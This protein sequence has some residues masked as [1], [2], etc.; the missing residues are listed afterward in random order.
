MPDVIK[1]GAKPMPA[2]DD[3]VRIDGG[4]PTD[5]KSV[6]PEELEKIEKKARKQI[7]DEQPGS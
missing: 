7:K 4:K 1:E 6:P 3:Q 2:T 5:D